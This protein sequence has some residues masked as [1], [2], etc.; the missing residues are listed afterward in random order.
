MENIN[1]HI[2]FCAYGMT[3]F[4]KKNAPMH[5][6]AMN[7][8]SERMMRNSEMP[9]DFMASSSKLSP[10]LPNV[11]SDANKMANGSANGTEVSDE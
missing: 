5:T 8:V 2:F 1:V 4:E 9:A 6:M 10:K 11:I 3:L 7:I